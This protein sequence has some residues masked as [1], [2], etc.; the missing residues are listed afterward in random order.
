[1]YVHIELHLSETEKDEPMNFFADIEH[2]QL[3]KRL[4]KIKMIR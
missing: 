1:M 2:Y 4:K 3:R